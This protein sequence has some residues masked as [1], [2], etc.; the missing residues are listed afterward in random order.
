MLAGLQTWSAPEPELMMVT[1][2]CHP[3][4]AAH[5]GGERVFKGTLGHFRY[6][7]LLLSSCLQLQVPETLFEEVVLEPC[8]QGQAWVTLSDSRR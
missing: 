3:E 1:R 4:S 6:I 8:E 5:G 2:C 7:I